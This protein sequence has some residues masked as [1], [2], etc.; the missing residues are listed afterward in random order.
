MTCKNRHV[1]GGGDAG[2]AHRGADGKFIPRRTAGVAELTC[3]LQNEAWIA[4]GGSEKGK[5]RKSML[6]FPN[7]SCNTL[8]A[9]K[10]ER[11]LLG[12]LRRG[13]YK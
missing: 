11:Q 2:T 13:C 12:K 5:A 6:C 10:N 1:S 7:Q 8:V 3:Y 9:S 4:K